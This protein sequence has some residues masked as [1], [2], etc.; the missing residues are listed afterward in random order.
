MPEMQQYA[1]E[2]LPED[3]ASSAARAQ[4]AHP[5]HPTTHHAPTTANNTPPALLGTHA[6]WGSRFGDLLVTF[7]TPLA[8]TRVR[9][10]HTRRP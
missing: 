7:A 2:A 1:G 8:A 9:F 4:P 6:T 3:A 5:G 10:H